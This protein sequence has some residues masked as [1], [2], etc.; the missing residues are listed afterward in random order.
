MPQNLTTELKE[1]Q[2][3]IEGYA[4]GYG[5]D[6]FDVIFEVLDWEEINEKLLKSMW[7]SKIESSTNLAKELKK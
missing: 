5:L 2:K 6:F 1:L 3:E 4:R 7:K